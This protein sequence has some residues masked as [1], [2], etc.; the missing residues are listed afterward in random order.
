MG[1]HTTVEQPLTIPN[2][3]VKRGRADDTV[4]LW[5]ESKCRPFSF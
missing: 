3:E 4:Y 1:D 2:R 5:R